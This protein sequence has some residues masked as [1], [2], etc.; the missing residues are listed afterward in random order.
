MPAGARHAT[1]DHRH[2]DPL[3]NDVAADP[4]G[5]GPKIKYENHKETAPEMMKFFP[6]LR[7][8]DLPDGEGWAIEWISLATHSGTISTRRTTIRPPWIAASAPSP[9]TRCRSNGACSRHQA[10]LPAFPERLCRH[11]HGRRGRAQ[12]HRPHAV[13]ARDRAGQHRGGQRYGQPDY[14]ATGCGMGREA[15]LYLLE[16]GVRVTGIDGWS[17]DAPFV[18]T[19]DKYAKTGDASLIW[20]ATA[21]AARS[22]TAIWRSCTTSK[23][24]LRRDS[25]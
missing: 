10:R 15:T 24:C 25:R 19:K 20:E 4:P 17:W 9:S 8:E 6:G 5:Y 2:L 7:A 21:L 14:V 16:R 13:A 11:R 22:A 3:E 12:A 18:Y 1:P 23:R